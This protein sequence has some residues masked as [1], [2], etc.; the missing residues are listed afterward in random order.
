MVIDP[1]V[2][3]AQFASE[4]RYWSTNA[5]CASMLGA[6]GW[7]QVL[8]HAAIMACILWLHTLAAVA[9]ATQAFQSEITFLFRLLCCN[10]TALHCKNKKA[11]GVHLCV[12]G[13]CNQRERT[14]RRRTRRQ[15]QRGESKPRMTYSSVWW[16][17]MMC[18]SVQSFLALCSQPTDPWLRSL[19][20]WSSGR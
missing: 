2:N 1:V 20:M 12:C 18:K 7:R 14:R 6:E 5:S 10:R 3:S 19:H 9:L 4:D 15:Q 16:A 13:L 17:W 8:W 11:S